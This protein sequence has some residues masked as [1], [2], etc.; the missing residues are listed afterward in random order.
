VLA[1]S[2]S[3]PMLSASAVSGTIATKKDKRARTRTYRS[4]EAQES[5][6]RPQKALEGIA[7]TIKELKDR[8]LKTS[9]KKLLFEYNPDEPLRLQRSQR[10]KE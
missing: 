6:R 4:T 7:K 5:T 9:A 3:K 10:T 8:P 1:R 2:K